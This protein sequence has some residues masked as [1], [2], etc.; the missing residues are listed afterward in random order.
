M[1]EL[2]DADAEAASTFVCKD[3]DEGAKVNDPTE[4]ISDRA[5]EVR[6]GWRGGSAAAAELAEAA[7]PAANEEEPT[8]KGEEGFLEPAGDDEGEPAGLSRKVAELTAVVVESSV[9]ETWSVTVSILFSEGEPEMTAGP[10]VA[11]A[12]VAVL[13]VARERSTDSLRVLPL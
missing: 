5:T 6:F 2:E 1:V 4:L 7:A 3:S 11:A 10:G 9:D 12:A 8:E 13:V